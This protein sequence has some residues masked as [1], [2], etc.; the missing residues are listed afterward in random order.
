MKNKKKVLAALLVVMMAASSNAVVFAENLQTSQ[1][2]EAEVTINKIDEDDSV[3]DQET[4]GSVEEHKIQIAMTELVEATPKNGS[5]IDEDTLK[6]AIVNASSEQQT[7]IQLDQDIALT[8]TLVISEDKNILLDLNG[9]TLTVSSDVNVLENKGTLII[10]NGIIAGMDK[11]SGT[12]GKGV[13]NQQSGNLT[14]NGRNTKLIGRS[15]LENYGVAVINDGT[16]TSYNR[17]A[18]YTEAGSN[19]V[20]NGGNIIAS[21]G[22][23]GMGR[24]VSAVGDITITGGYFYA[25]GT[26]GAGD[27][28]MNAISIFNGATLLIKPSQGN[29]VTVISE[30]DYAV[31]SYSGI[32]EIYGGNFA[33]NGNRT[34][35]QSLQNGEITLYGGSYHHEPD[36]KFVADGYVVV[37]ESEKYNIYKAQDSQSITV[38]NYAELKQAVSG[39]ITEPKNIT[40]GANIVIP[41]NESI[42][43]KKGYTLTIPQQCTLTV[44]GLLSLQ[45]ELINNG[46]LNVSTN[47][48]IE[49]PLQVIS[50]GTITNYPTVNNGVCSISTPMQ[51]QWLA[52]MVENSGSPTYVVLTQDITMPNDINFTPIGVS[53]FYA[54]SVFDGQGHQINNLKVNATTFDGGLFGQIG[55]VT[56]KDLT[57]NESAVISTNQYIGTLA[58]FAT[59]N[60]SI[61]NVKVQNSSV[62]SSISYG[63]GG[64]IGQIWDKD[65]SRKVEFIGCCLDN[66]EVEGYANVGAFWGTSTGSLATIGIYNCDIGGMVNAIN[67][68]GGICG[69]YGNSAPVEIIGLN[70]TKLTATVNGVQTDKLIAHTTVD[71]NLDQADASQY[72]AVKD[73]NNNW[74]GIDTNIA[75]EADIDGVPYASFEDALK[76]AKSNDT[77][78]LKNDITLTENVTIPEG[79][80]VDIPTGITLNTNDY[81]INN[82]GKII[83]EKGGKLDGDVSNTGNGTVIDNNSGSSGGN[84]GGSIGTP[85]TGTPIGTGTWKQSPAGWWY[86]NPDGTYPANQWKYLDSGKGYKAW[87]LFNQNGYIT[88]GWQK[89][90]N[91]WYY[92]NCSGEMQ[93]GWQF[94]NNK[95]YYLN[96]N[97]AMATGWVKDGNKWY[98]MNKDGSM[99]FGWLSWA[100]YWYHLDSHGVMSTGWKQVNGKWYY[101]YAENGRM[102]ANTTTPDGYRV[103]PDGAWIK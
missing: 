52:H 100:G 75:I 6:S 32:L 35:I 29:T 88:F 11:G 43:L 68:N 55:D 45:G 18:I 66:V 5:I 4:T 2:Q 48:F 91:T 17:N 12:K 98:F 94:I 76:N 36:S 7:T 24:A 46:I 90:G 8:N 77:I 25:N 16:I 9:H 86:Q 84:G 50:N 82:N 19:T 51:L 1:N 22:S 57:I 58:G 34:D 15:G 103:G 14:I 20:I 26:S 59:G 92:M 67:V 93:T 69:G 95:W 56:V 39:P 96:S 10:Q 42:F 72:Q 27:N 38:K 89:V 70:S 44:N 65:A 81:T 74:V 37:Q 28:Y 47:G 60:C 99:H 73:E 62:K 78:I 79:V 54:D 40:L 41:Q 63:V 31:S 102:A 33:C 97:G 21:S 71:N 30:T 53:S 61:K 85:G 49:N 83:V 3:K 101:M 13:V 80:T 64:L 87:Y 23:S